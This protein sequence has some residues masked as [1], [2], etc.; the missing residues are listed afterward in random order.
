MTV[1]RID[2]PPRRMAPPIDTSRPRLGP[3]APPLPPVRGR[4]QTAGQFMFQLVVYCSRLKSWVLTRGWSEHDRASFIV[5]A[6]DAM[7]AVER[8]MKK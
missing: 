8:E 2:K 1:D 6:S 3:G 7:D 5:E 4:E